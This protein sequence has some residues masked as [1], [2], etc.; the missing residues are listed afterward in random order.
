MNVELKNNLIVYLNKMSKS[1]VDKIQQLYKMTN[2]IKGGTIEE[3]VNNVPN[4]AV[5]EGIIKLCKKQL[6]I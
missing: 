1:D 2:K 4:D 6:G 5:L 3:F